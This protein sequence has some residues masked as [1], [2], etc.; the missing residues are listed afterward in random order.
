[1]NSLENTAETLKK[2]N[3]RPSPIRIAV[4]EALFDKRWHPTVDD[5]YG[6][7]I[8]EIPTLSRTTLYNTLKLF[9][10][11]GLVKEV[12]ISPKEM[13]YEAVREQHG[14]FQCK[15]CG[16]IYD[17]PLPQLESIELPA[18]MQNAYIEQ[19][20]LNLTGICH[21]CQHKTS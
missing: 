17:I 1:M 20:Q 14:H 7:V 4:Y 6:I 9:I 15:C 18:H 12:N 3:I 13:N 2:L 19:T 8:E 16:H 5:L 21:Q 10:Q 11:T